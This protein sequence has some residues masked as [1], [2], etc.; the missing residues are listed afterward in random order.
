MAD[1]KIIIDTSLDT[2][3]IEKGLADAE[4]KVKKAANTIS[5]SAERA[6]KS[7]GKETEEAKKK[8]EALRA[9]LDDPMRSFTVKADNLSSGPISRIKTAFEDSAKA[10]SR[11]FSE[12][13]EDLDKYSTALEPITGAIKDKI[14]KIADFAKSA[15][16]IAVGAIASV[17]T[18]IVGLGTMGVSYNAEIEKYQTALTTM[19][20]SSEKAEAA[21]EAIKKD[22]ATTPF[23]VKGLVQANNFLIS[24]GESAEE[25][26]KTIM[27]LGDAVAATGGGNDELQRMSQ[28]LQQIKNAGKATSADIKQFAYAGID[29]YGILA[30]YT[31]KSTKD[32]KEMDITYEELTAALQQAASEGGRYYDAMNNQSKTFNGQLSNLKDNASA[33]VG[34][35]FE[36]I[37]ETLTKK[38]MPAANDAIQQL[39]DAFQKDGV[40]GLIDAGGNVIANL[41]IGMGKAAPKLITTAAGLIKSIGSNMIKHKDEMLTAAKEIVKALADGLLSLLPRSISEPI[42]KIFDDIGKS[43]ESGGLKRGIEKAAKLVGKLVQAFGDIVDSVGPAVIKIIDFIGDHF[44]VIATAAIGAVTAI[45]T[46]KKTVDVMS[47]VSKVIETAQQALTALGAAA[48]A[49]PLMLIPVVIAGAA[50]AFA[51]LAANVETTDPQLQAFYDRIDAIN[52]S[53]DENRQSMSQMDDEIQNT[54]SSYQQSASELEN[55]KSRLGE[56]FDSQGRLKDGCAETADYILNQLNEAMGTQYSLTADGFIENTDGAKVSLQ[57]LNG[58][59][60]E[61]I[62]KTKAQAIQAAAMDEYTQAVK[63]NATAQKDLSD[64]ESAYQESLSAYIQAYAAY[65]DAIKAANE[66]TKQYG[67]VS[68]D[69]AS[70]LEEAQTALEDASGAFSSAGDAYR[71]A[72]SAAAESQTKVAGLNAVIDSLATGTREGTDAAAEMYE[73]IPQYSQE[74]AS[75]IIASQNLINAALS[76]T[77]PNLT[78]LSE[79]FE[80]AAKAIRENGG[81]IPEELQ[82]SLNEAIACIDKLGPDG[83][84]SMIAA[85]GSVLEGMADMN[86]K[87]KGL[88]EAS[89]DEILSAFQ[90]LVDSGAAQQSGVDAAEAVSSGVESVDTRTP[91]AAKADDVVYGLTGEFE[92]RRYSVV[93]AAQSAVQGAN[94]GIDAAQMPEHAAET[95]QSACDNTVNTYAAGEAGA[96]HAAAEYAKNSNDGLDSANVDGHYGRVADDAKNEFIGNLSSGNA[97]AYASGDRLGSSADSGLN[98]NNY[99]GKAGAVGDSFQSYFHGAIENGY[100]LAGT[101]GDQLGSIAYGRLNSYTSKARAVGANFSRGFAQGINANTGAIRSAAENAAQQALDAAKRRLDVR[102]PSHVMDKEVGRMIPLGIAQGI[103]NKTPEMLRQM[104]KSVSGLIDHSFI[105]DRLQDSMNRSAR[106]AAKPMGGLAGASVTNV[107]NNDNSMHQE[108]TYNVPTASP[109]EVA[110]TQ[111]QAFRAFAGGVA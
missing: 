102:S 65:S 104:D 61:N 110:K 41:L 16:K 8:V 12:Y 81:K 7:V 97:G 92:A 33:L 79:G 1:G 74:A 88:S 59:I 73:L 23:D 85:M 56:C 11:C 58:T 5:E 64:A 107:Y 25:S 109:S 66:D 31:G 96:Y 40:D 19:L 6:A 91:A 60:D 54:V 18:A 44:D 26:R 38:L 95:A 43:M 27:A 111:R 53:V 39:S 75:G 52:Q 83:K 80:M 24:T 51:M 101:A 100:E 20:G 68:S 2:K 32:V 45:L 30:D 89:A 28:N 71:E 46:F 49:N 72:G 78:D 93:A 42:R 90:E 37:S 15:A 69:T 94:E 22:A 48:S 47:A 99:P 57:E 70:R 50:S 82:N 55:W 62:S 36:P 3:G 9:N 84:S 63:D 35:V 76:G 108:N 14:G 87:F 98:K 34:Q 106:A 13:T 105:L 21:L 4:K 17:S 86:P 10:S 77:T 103:K 67:E 29:I